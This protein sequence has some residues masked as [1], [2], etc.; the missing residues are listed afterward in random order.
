MMLL[1]WKFSNPLDEWIQAADEVEVFY[2]YVE[3]NRIEIYQ[4]F[5]DQGWEFDIMTDGS[6]Q[7]KL[8]KIEDGDVGVLQEV[9]TGFSI[10]QGQIQAGNIL[11]TLFLGTNQYVNF[12]NIG[13]VIDT[14]TSSYDSQATEE[15]FIELA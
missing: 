9:N 8:T 15:G 11:D 14:D 3:S 2:K 10:G 6:H 13:E 7:I 12:Q 4:D 1:C 5:A